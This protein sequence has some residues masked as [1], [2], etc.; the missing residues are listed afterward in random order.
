MKVEE[1]TQWVGA[2][3]TNLQALET[4]LRYFLL[5]ANNQT[6]D[7]PK[8]GDTDTTITLLTDF[9]FLGN[10]MVLYNEKLTE[11]ETKYAVESASV[12]RIRNAFAHGRLVNLT[13]E[14]PAT[15][16]KFG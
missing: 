3:V 16:W 8:R 2:I 12:I 13:T 15:L 14:F 11:A 5:K 7:F 10:L 9:T 1:H 6:P 4:L